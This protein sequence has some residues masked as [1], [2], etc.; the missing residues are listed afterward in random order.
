[1][2]NGATNSMN[3]RQRK[4]SGPARTPVYVFDMLAH[5]KDPLKNA[6]PAA[7]DARLQKLGS[8]M[9]KALRLQSGSIDLEALRAFEERCAALEF[10][11][12]DAAGA[13]PFT[14]FDLSSMKSGFPAPAGRNRIKDGRNGSRVRRGKSRSITCNPGSKA[15]SRQH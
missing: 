12:I 6:R 2:F 4:R 15:A 9:E 8:V 7:Q 3:C 5:V 11:S 10:M 1:M 13:D 14:H